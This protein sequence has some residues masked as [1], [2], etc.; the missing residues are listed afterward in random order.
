M[1]TREVLQVYETLQLGDRVEVIHE[2]KV[3]FRSWTTSVTGRVVRTSR[4]RHGLHYQRNADDRVFRDTL[5][6]QHDDGELST[7]T[8]DEYSQL[9][10]LQRAAQRS[11]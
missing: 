7:V 4:Q 9:K 8:L 11:V 6:L 1:E 3:G 10:V 2:V 5:V